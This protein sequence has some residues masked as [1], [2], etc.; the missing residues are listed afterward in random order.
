MNWRLEKPV[1]QRDVVAHWQAVSKSG[2][3]A[4]HEALEGI[5]HVIGIST[6]YFVA[7]LKS[8]SLFRFMAEHF[9]VDSPHFENVTALLDALYHSEYKRMVRDGDFF[10]TFLL[11]FR[12]CVALRDTD[13]RGPVFEIVYWVVCDAY[14]R[15]YVELSV[16]I[17]Y[18]PIV[19]HMMP[20]EHLAGH[21]LVLPL[22]I[23]D[24]APQN[25]DHMVRTGL[26][27]WFLQTNLPVHSHIN[28]RMFTKQ[29]HMCATVRGVSAIHPSLLEQLA[30]EHPACAM[31]IQNTLH[32]S[33][34]HFLM[35]TIE[36]AVALRALN[37]PVLQLL[38]ILDAVAPNHYAFH[39]KWRV[40]AQIKHAQPATQM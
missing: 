5:R 37:L 38:T 27:D 30:T 3:A 32:W 33:R 4:I 28:V 12:S 20:N 39:G 9:R 34:S 35:R 18:A 8:T 24:L 15:A 25:F 21:E 2:D 16:R 19:V 17:D 29:L 11:L 22:L 10:D 36:L 40:L 14:E 31:R 1:R 23:E 7:L 6:G 13:D 26:I